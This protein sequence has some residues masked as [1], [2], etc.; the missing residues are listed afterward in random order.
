MS[1][2][3]VIHLLRVGRMVLNPA[4]AAA[5]LV[6]KEERD[7]SE[8]R[9]DLLLPDRRRHRNGHLGERRHAARVVVRA[10]LLHVRR[11]D[12]ALGWS[13]APGISAT[14]VRA[15]PVRNDAAMFTFIITGVFGPASASRLRSVAAARGDALNPKDLR[16]SSFGTLLHWRMSHLSRGVALAAPGT[17]AFRYPGTLWTR[18]GGAAGDAGAAEQRARV[19]VAEHDRAFQLFAGIVLLGA[20]AD[21][22]E[23]PRDAAFDRGERIDAEREPI[24]FF[25]STTSSG[26][27]GPADSK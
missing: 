3:N 19:G 9:G 20:L 4:P 2:E 27:P 11:Q 24:L 21:I 16:A 12:D 25:D 8:R 5:D 6:Q 13:D 22:H 15:G 7:G 23:P 14:S 1:S 10:G 17:S 26:A 18:P